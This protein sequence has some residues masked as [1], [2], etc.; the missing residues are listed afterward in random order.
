MH[1]DPDGDREPNRPL[2]AR[3][4]LRFEAK[5]DVNH[6]D[7][8]WRPDWLR[9]GRRNQ[10][11]A[12]VPSGALSLHDGVPTH[13]I[14]HVIGVSKEP[15]EGKPEKISNIGSA[16][17]EFLGKTNTGGI[18]YI[19]DIDGHVLKMC[20][21]TSGVSHSNTSF[22]RDETV[23][24]RRS[25][26]IEHAYAGYSDAH[27]AAQLRATADLLGALKTKF[28]IDGRNIAG[29]GEVRC[30]STDEALDSLAVRT[31]KG[32]RTAEQKKLVKKIEDAKR[33]SLKQANETHKK[34]KKEFDEVLSESEIAEKV[35]AYVETKNLKF[36]YESK[37]G[38]ALHPSGRLVT[39]PGVMFRW[40][41]LAD[42]GVVPDPAS[43]D[44][45][46]DWAHTAYAG[47]YATAETP[48]LRLRIGDD[49]GTKKWGG[50]VRVNFSPGSPVR[51]LHDDLR[52]IGYAVPIGLWNGDGHEFS[53]LLKN[54]V[55]AF[56]ARYMQTEPTNKTLHGEVDT[57]AAEMIKRVV[58]AYGRGPM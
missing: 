10:K 43:V 44:L 4:L 47:I 7:V 57:A 21:E 30:I 50:K 49:D 1:A 28:S 3:H 58:A 42:R 24:N 33:A 51:E 12:I 8:D 40:G 29:H 22:W 56:K 36:N 13:I 14:L 45:D 16:I 26:G 18:H 38:S 46:V 52:A 32:E 9:R 25:V 23:M 34:K 39:C 35:I 20:P 53:G 41:Y 6:I 5:Q 31:A 37:W 27:P 54:A 11:T 17:N 15:A 48:P 2:P 19:V 55:K